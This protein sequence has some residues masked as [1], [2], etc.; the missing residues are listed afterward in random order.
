MMI[1][2]AA[3]AQSHVHLPS[4]WK[5][6]A[7]I[8]RRVSGHLCRAFRSRRKRKASSLASVSMLRESNSTKGSWLT[9]ICLFGSF[10]W[11]WR[12]SVRTKSSWR[13]LLSSLTPHCAPM[14]S[15][16]DFVLCVNR[17]NL[18]FALVGTRPMRRAHQITRNMGHPSFTLFGRGGQQAR[19]GL[20]EA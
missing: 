9:F 2:H 5:A 14:D 4:V 13:A 3:V 10:G 20:R 18:Q 16:I 8:W 6:V 17:A 7:T 1:I 19:G 11:V 12:V 15:S